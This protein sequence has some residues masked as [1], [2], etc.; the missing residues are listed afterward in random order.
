MAARTKYNLYKVTYTG[1][2]VKEEI[3][4]EK[5]SLDECKCYLVRMVNYDHRTRFRTL[6]ECIKYC[7]NVTSRGFSR[8]TGSSQISYMIYPSK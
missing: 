3:I 6:S 8:Y 5:K 2:K 7:D 4:S 1:D